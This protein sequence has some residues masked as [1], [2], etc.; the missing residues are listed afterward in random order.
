VTGNAFWTTEK[1][2]KDALAAS[3]SPAGDVPGSLVQIPEAS[4]IALLFFR[5]EVAVL[6]KR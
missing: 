3:S 6:R 4:P 1:C 5:G 2:A